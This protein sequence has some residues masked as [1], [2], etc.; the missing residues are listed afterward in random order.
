MLV[1]AFTVPEF[2]QLFSRENLLPLI[3]FSMIL[4]FAVSVAGP[5]GEKVAG[6]LKAGLDVT[7]GM[8]R[9]V[10]LAAPVGLGCYFADTVGRLGGQLL[11]GYLNAFLLYLA[12]AAVVFFGVNTL[13]M[14]LCG[15]WN[16]VRSF[17]KGILT[18]ALTAVATSSS[19]ACLPVN[20]EAARGMGVSGGIADSVIPLGTNLHKDGS[21]MGGVVKVLFLLT[22]F[23][24]PYVSF[25]KFLLVIGIAILVGAVMGAVPTGGMTGELLICSLL[26]FPPEM[27]AALMVISTVIDIPATLLNSTGNVVAARLVDRLLR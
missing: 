27:A 2:L 12:V 24:V 15:G 1:R 20:I 6:G 25:G 26:G 10:M 16:G 17:W 5:S 23:G 22:L 11:G 4:G 8:V 7:V 21:V 13:Y 14:F 3:V 19:A 18:P 9:I